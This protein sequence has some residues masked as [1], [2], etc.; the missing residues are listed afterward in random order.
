MANADR[1]VVP[2]E[3]QH[4]QPPAH[5]LANQMN[6]ILMVLNVAERLPIFSEEIISA[7]S[8]GE[9]YERLIRQIQV[10]HQN[11]QSLAE[12]SVKAKFIELVRD[13]SDPV[14]NMTPMS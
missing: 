8:E 12:L 9:P 3:R 1:N 14:K 2:F 11:I 13:N 6:D 4:P 7:A 5:S 10:L